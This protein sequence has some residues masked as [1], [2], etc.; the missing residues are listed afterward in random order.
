M[1]VEEQRERAVGMDE[2]ARVHSRS[3]RN[4]QEQKEQQ[5]EQQ[6]DGDTSAALRRAGHHMTDAEH[7]R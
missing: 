1:L 7:C 3:N 5:K 6:Y 2:H 4:T